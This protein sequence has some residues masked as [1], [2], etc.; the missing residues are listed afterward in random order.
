MI[1]AWGEVGDAV[2]PGVAGVPDK[3][4][5]AGTTRQQVVALP[6]IEDVV[7]ATAG[8]RIVADQPT[9]AVVTAMTEDPVRGSGTHQA[10]AAIITLQRTGLRIEGGLQ[11]AE[12][13]VAIAV[14]GLDLIGQL[15]RLLGQHLRVAEAAE[16]ERR[17]V[18]CTRY[19]QRA[20]LGGRA[21][22]VAPVVQKPTNGDRVAVVDQGH[23]A[24]D[25]IAQLVIHMDIAG[26]ERHIALADISRAEHV[27]VVGDDRQDRQ[28]DGAIAALHLSDALAEAGK[29]VVAAVAEARAALRVDH[30]TVE[31]VETNVVSR[32][33]PLVADGNV[34]RG[35]VDA[36]GGG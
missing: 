33:D 16:G 9:Q 30:Q 11:V 5:R 20:E 27:I 35:T 25:V 4:I 18:R 21:D 23:R 1:L 10:V 15:D 26:R 19:L 28:A 36:A 22:F 31:K 7:T 2:N 8:Q 34:G 13:R 24:G 29:Q 14:G 17:R 32:I 3:A 12:D 6:A